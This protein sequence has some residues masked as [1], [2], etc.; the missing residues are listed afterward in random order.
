[1]STYSSLGLSMDRFATILEGMT[2]LVE[3]WGGKSVST[4]EVELL[5][6]MLRQVSYQV[7]TL[8]EK[9]QALYNA[10][11]VAN[12]T[13]TQLDN[14]LELIGMRRQSAAKSTVTL[15]CTVSKACTIPA[16]HM[17]RTSANVYFSLDTPLVF[18]GSG[19]QTVTATCTKFG[20]YNAGAG[21][22]S[23]IVNAVN[24]W[25]A[26]TNTAAATPGRSREEDPAL[27][28]RH[29]VAVSTSGERDAASIAEAVG[30]VDG[31]SA[32]LVEEDYTSSQPVSVYV[33]GG[34]DDEIAAAMDAQL[35]V[36]IGTAGTTEVAVYNE[37]LKQNKTIRFTR[38]TD[39]DLYISLT[40]HINSALFPADGEL[41]IK[42]ALVRLFDGQNLGDDVIY[43]ELPGAIYS[44]PGV[45][46]T[47]LTIGT[48]P[49]SMGASDVSVGSS[50]RAVLDSTN[51]VISYV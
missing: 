17:V 19:S 42:E 20:P 51:V 1:M 9:V 2:D 47:S 38:G 46:I 27:Q 22:V 40:L 16:G 6:H 44:V 33:I 37:T 15:T 29:T 8:N 12:L 41:Q 7:D 36:G 3:A 5:G 35:T 21:E 24:G 39:L 10:L 25:T 34:E 43:F 11:S 23:I 28:S 48:S 30:G 14:V 49:Y 18:T 50:Q 26:V 31:V 4:D 45:T 32:V 13:G